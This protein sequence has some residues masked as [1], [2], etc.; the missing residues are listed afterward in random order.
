MQDLKSGFH[1]PQLL[2][3]VAHWAAG[4]WSCAEARPHNVAS[5]AMYPP[6]ARLGTELHEHGPEHLLF[7]LFIQMQGSN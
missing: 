1:T 6:A 3:S 4:T 7:W 2:H 5:T